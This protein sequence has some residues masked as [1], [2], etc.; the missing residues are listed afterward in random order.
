MPLPYRQGIFK[1]Q[2]PQKYK[3]TSLPVT[4]SSWEFKFC[5]F[6]DLNENIMEW[7]SEEPKIPYL[8]PNTRTMW[9]YHPDFL[10]RIKDPKNPL[11]SRVELIEIKPYKQTLAPVAKKGKKAQSLL[12][13]TQVYNMNQAKWQAAR[14]FCRRQGWTFK[15]LT[16]RDLF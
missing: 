12:K 9:N 6:L 11:G 4:R 2:N 10:V 13:E 5:R 16:E 15:V 7:S 8:N 3:G 1:P 14:E